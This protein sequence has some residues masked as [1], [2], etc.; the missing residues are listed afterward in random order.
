M[1][2][3]LTYYRDGSGRPSLVFVPT[4]TQ[5]DIDGYDVV[6]VGAAVKG[7]IDAIAETWIAPGGDISMIYWNGE[8]IGAIER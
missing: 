4:A 5:E 6:E 8:L 1:F 2:T 7:V 3:I